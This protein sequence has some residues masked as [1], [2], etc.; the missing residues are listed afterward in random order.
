MSIGFKINPYDPC[1][2]NKIVKHQQLTVVC[3]VDDLEASHRKPAVVTKISNWF[4]STYERLFD[5]GSGEMQISR[6]S[7]IH[8]YLGMTLDFTLPGQVMITMIPYVEEILQL[9]SGHNKSE[10]TAR[11]SAAEHLFKVNEETESLT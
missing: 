6:G 3:H 10:S 1:V 5:D 4:K 9:F 8:E 7:K 2:T 11:T